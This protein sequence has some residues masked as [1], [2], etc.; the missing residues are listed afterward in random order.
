[1]DIG[2]LFQNFIRPFSIAASIGV[3]GVANSEPPIPADYAT[4]TLSLTRQNVDSQRRLNSKAQSHKPAVAPTGVII[5]NVPAIDR[6]F[7]K[8]VLPEDMTV[9]ILD[10]QRIPF[11]LNPALSVA[12][13][14]SHRVR[15][16]KGT[17]VLINDNAV[18][19]LNSAPEL[20][21]KYGA[22]S[23]GV[24]VLSDRVYTPGSNS[25]TR[26]NDFPGDA[27]RGML[28]GISPSQAQKVFD[29]REDLKR[30]IDA[31]LSQ[32]RPFSQGKLIKTKAV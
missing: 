2:K 26:V 30:F 21:R 20:K 1:M 18:Q 29:T 23:K 10:H 12:Q 22:K 3:A 16:A 28:F 8:M 13:E 25:F 27:P 7:V 32:S 19:L 24:L 14:A 4:R 11:A 31:D 15:L 17:E 5:K 9:A 6:K